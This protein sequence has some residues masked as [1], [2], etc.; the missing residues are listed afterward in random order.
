VANEGTS[1]GRYTLPEDEYQA[2]VEY[3]TKKTAEELIFKI[4]SRTF[5]DE[6]D[7]FRPW[8]YK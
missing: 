6:P 5:F 1:F 7:E 3:L 2:F 8:T 4:L